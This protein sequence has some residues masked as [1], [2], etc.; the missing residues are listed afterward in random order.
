MIEKRVLVKNIEVN[1]K[2]FGNGEPFLILH[3]WGSKSDRWQKVAE[4]LVEKNIMVIVPDLPGFGQSQ[5]PKN[6][7]SLDNYVEW[8]KEFSDLLPELKNGFY[9]LGHSFGGSLAAKFCIKYSQKVEKLFLVSAS[10]LRK[11]TLKK[12]I[13]YKISKIVKLFSFLP[14]YELFRKVFYKFIFKKSDYPYVDGVMKE[15]YLN[16]ISDDLS[17]KLSFIKVPTAIIWGDKDTLT[18]VEDAEF[19]NKKIQNS[20][21]IIIF[22]AQHSLQIETPDILVKKV[23]ENL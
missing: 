14:Y 23:L 4:L 1:Y 13:L 5:E 3:G 17:Q 6:P 19:I 16:V 8:A 9:L 10:C 21:L 12:K 20:K 11:A 7:W 2:V 15:T 18:P 22:N